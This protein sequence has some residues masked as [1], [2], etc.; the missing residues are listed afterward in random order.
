MEEI[1]PIIYRVLYLP[2]GCSGYLPSTVTVVNGYS[3]HAQVQIPLYPCFFRIGLNYA[4]STYQYERSTETQKLNP[5]KKTNK[6][7]SPQT[8]TST[9]YKIGL[10]VTI[11]RHKWSYFTPKSL[12]F[13]SR[14]TGFFSIPVS[15]A[16]VM[17]PLLKTGRDPFCR[18]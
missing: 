5:K 9:C 6:L 17:G 10:I 15:G 3:A 2:G 12:A 11:D 7:T 13:D 8:F 1:L 18:I 14:V 4:V 16:S